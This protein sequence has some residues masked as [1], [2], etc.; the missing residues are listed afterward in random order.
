M[1]EIAEKLYKLFYGFTLAHGKMTLKNSVKK[2]GK[3]E[4]EHQHV[5]EKVTIETW[6]KHLTGESIGIVPVHDDGVSCT[7]GAIDIDFYDSFSHSRLIDR[8]NKYSLPLVV[9][10]SK[11]GGAHCYLFFKEK[12]TAELVHTTLREWTSYIGYASNLKGNPT[13][14]FPK[15]FKLLVEQGDMGSFINMPYD[16]GN[17]TKRYC[18]IKENENIR[19]LDLEEFLEYANSKRITLNQLSK[20][21]LP[22]LE[23]FVDGPPCLQILAKEKIEEGGR[24]IALFGMGCYARKAFPDSWEKKIEEYNHNYLEKPLNSKEMNTIIKSVGRK[25]Y[26]Y[27]CRQSPLVNHCHR[28]DCIQK[29]YGVGTDLGEVPVLDTL[30]KINTDPPTYILSMLDRNGKPTP[31]VLNSEE[32]LSARKIKKKCLEKMNYLPFIPK[33][34]EWE[35]LIQNVLENIIIIDVPE[36]SSLSGQLFYQLQFFLTRK[37]RSGNKKELLNGKPLINEDKIYFRLVDFCQYLEINHFRAFKPHEITALFRK[38]QEC[39]EMGHRTFNVEGKCIQ[40]WFI[41]KDENDLELDIPEEIEK[42]ESP[43]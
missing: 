36:D 32:L 31:V 8:I 19:K 30:Q 23:V 33:Q 10:R 3:L 17:K 41:P 37:A 16:N 11:S 28:N 9:L 13:E 15:Q 5:R 18:I 24:N 25:D 29:K 7:F 6:E 35:K 34:N 22:K 40:T 21:K 38:K 12:V 4:A 42:N 27:P 43:F 1:R 39:G 14:I 20:I 26:F 2:T